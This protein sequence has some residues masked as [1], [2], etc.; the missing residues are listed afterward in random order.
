MAKILSVEEIYGDNSIESEIMKSLAERALF[1]IEEVREAAY[2]TL[3]E[4]YNGMVKGGFE[5]HGIMFL[6]IQKDD[7]PVK[8]V[9]CGPVE[10]PYSAHSVPFEIG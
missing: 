5:K 8:L 9:D 6:Y 4:R 3:K 2:K 1:D 10:T 7:S